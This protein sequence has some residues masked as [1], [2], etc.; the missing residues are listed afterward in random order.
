MRIVRIIV[1]FSFSLLLGLIALSPVLDDV[2]NVTSRVKQDVVN[3]NAQL[4]AID[5]TNI[6]VHH[7]YSG[8]D[9][10]AQ[11]FAA[12]K[13]PHVRIA[14][15]LASLTAAAFGVFFGIYQRRVDNR[16]F[17]RP[18]IKTRAVK[19]LAVKQQRI[20]LAE[21]EGIGSVGLLAAGSP[22]QHPRRV[23]A[24][25]RAPR[26]I[27]PQFAAVASRARSLT[28]A[29]VAATSEFGV[30]ENTSRGVPAAAHSNG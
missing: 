2:L 13:K 3:K 19:P 15:A 18:K 16:R 7:Y 17:R 11:M 25:E 4:R 27:E 30:T 26:V 29:P 8:T 28:F 22:Y 1:W 6:E 20:G 12:L 23:N 24:G 14:G 5:K 21:F 9:T 10:N